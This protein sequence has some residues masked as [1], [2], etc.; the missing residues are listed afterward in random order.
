MRKLL[1][2]FFWWLKKIAKGVCKD[3]GQTRTVEL[4]IGHHERTLTSPP[5]LLCVNT[6]DFHL[7]NLH[8]ITKRWWLFVIYGREIHVSMKMNNLLTL[9]VRAE[10]CQCCFFC[11]WCPC[12]LYSC[13]FPLCIAWLCLVY[14]KCLTTTMFTIQYLGGFFLLEFFLSFFG[15]RYWNFYFISN[16][17]LSWAY[18]NS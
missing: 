16:Q 7:V 14:T 13:I 8:S 4:L 3:M 17:C 18:I 12:Y 10:G 9:T 6:E 11:L 5:H 15:E 2:W 1:G